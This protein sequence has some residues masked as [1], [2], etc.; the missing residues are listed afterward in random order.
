VRALSTAGEIGKA[1]VKE[2]GPALAKSLLEIGKTAIQSKD[3]AAV[4]RAALAEATKVSADLELRAS[5]AA[6]GAAKKAIKKALK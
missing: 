5:F 6:K 1:L 4:A 2:F 3:S